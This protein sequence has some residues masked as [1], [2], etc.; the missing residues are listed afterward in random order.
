MSQ[1]GHR[2]PFAAQVKLGELCIDIRELFL[3]MSPEHQHEVAK[4]IA[5]DERLLELL[6][7]YVVENKIDWSDGDSW[8]AG[9]RTGAASTLIERA[10]IALLPLLPKMGREFIEKL[11][12]ERDKGHHL[13]AQWRDMC[14]KLQREW[15]ASQYPPDHK[16][17]YSAPRNK[18]QVAA[19]LAEF[20]RGMAQ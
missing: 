4:V 7:C 14:W 3:Q 12:E 5:C 15:C 18:E 6:C 11:I 17:D 1:A 2:Y 13:A 8:M 9:F 19:A 10:R 20:E 16:I